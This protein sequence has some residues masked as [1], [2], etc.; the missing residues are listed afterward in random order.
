MIFTM[1][2]FLLNQLNSAVKM[3]YMLQENDLIQKQLE[4][5]L[6]VLRAN[7]LELDNLSKSDVLT[8][9]M[10]RRGFFQSAEQFMKEQFAKGEKVLVSYIDMNNLKIM[11]L[12]RNWVGKP[13]FN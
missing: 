7:N 5:H 2:D 1:G 4:E 11:V 13:H 9:I 3:I 12:V 8:G 10:N 6:S